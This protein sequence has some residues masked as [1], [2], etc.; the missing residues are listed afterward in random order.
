MAKLYFRYGAMNSGKSTALL[1]AAFN[2]EERGHQVLLAKP[3]VDTKGDRDIVSRLGNVREVDFTIE[4]DTSVIERF[5]QHRTRIIEGHGRDVSCLL[6]DEAQFLS[7]DQV[8]DLLRIAL[9][10]DIPVLAYGIRT[11]FQTVAFPGSRRLLEIAHAVE[12]LKTICRC[13][14]KAI[15]NARKIDGVFVFTGD[16][17]AIDASTELSEGRVHEVTYESLCGVCYLEESGGVLN[18]RH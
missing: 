14:R 10:D 15:F 13:G 6:I 3:A 12:E 5:Q 17:V 1:Q 4:P 9:L 18:G 11:D 7:S 8:D 2:Y 16:Q